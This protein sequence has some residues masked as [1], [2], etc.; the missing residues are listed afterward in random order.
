[1]LL[2]KVQLLLVLLFALCLTV[3]A[4]EIS[5]EAKRGLW[6]GIREDTG[7]SV[8]YLFVGEDSHEF[9][10]LNWAPLEA[11]TVSWSER[12][13]ELKIPFRG[14]GFV[15]QG[16]FSDDWKLKGT[17]QIPH[18]QFNYSGEWWSKK[19]V[20]QEE[21]SPW[22]FADGKG[23][24]NPVNT[25]ADLPGS[26]ESEDV[27]LASWEKSVEKTFYPLWT[28]TIYSVNGAYVEEVRTENLAL[29]YKIFE[30]L[31]PSVLGKASVISE[32][33]G[34]VA[35]KI[36]GA[37]PSYKGNPV[38]VL[39][40]S[41]GKF[42]FEIFRVTE[43]S[44]LLLIG[45]DWVARMISEEDDIPTY[46]AEAALVAEMEAGGDFTNIP[47]RLA[48]RGIA[49]FLSSRLYPSTEMYFGEEVKDQL[50]EFKREI[51]NKLKGA[52]RDPQQV[53]LSSRERRKTYTVLMD[54]GRFLLEKEENPNSLLD[55]S[56][57]E[58]Q[59][60]FQEFLQE[61]E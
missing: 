13:F 14:V 51:L 47:G 2:K 25:L 48:V 1:M 58:I 57:R 40:P 18:P 7:A 33:F 56:S 12:A 26:F 43:G 60:A 42:D 5:P 38:P 55:L 11:E 54:F 41:V 17:W 21:F 20:D 32:Q 24:A 34:D 9:Y 52:I 45:A 50:P 8:F 19:V 22:S 10:G 61:E 39:M 27:F 15:I 3:P 30:N 44:P 35:E 29:A 36:R 6:H 53:F 49:A 37:Y 59:A 31:G 46:L 16:E 23:L 28:T 4:A